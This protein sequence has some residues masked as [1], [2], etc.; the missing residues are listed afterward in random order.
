MTTILLIILQKGKIINNIYK[1]FIILSM[2]T[3]SYPNQYKERFFA[4]YTSSLIFF[5][6]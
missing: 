1:Y 4:L 5:K 6:L 3:Y 2:N